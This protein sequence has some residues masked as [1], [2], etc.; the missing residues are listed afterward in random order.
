[1]LSDSSIQFCFEI[2]FL[3]LLESRDSFLEQMK[4]QTHEISNGDVKHSLAILNGI[5]NRPE[6]EEN[7]DEPNNHLNWYNDGAT[8]NRIETAID[9]FVALIK[10]NANNVG[11][12]ARLGFDSNN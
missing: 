5:Q 12:D 11:G 3:T 1:M 4:Q 2:S 10:E 6:G 9:I 7:N 8:M